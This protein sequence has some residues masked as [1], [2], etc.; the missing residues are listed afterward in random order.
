MNFIYEFPYVSLIH[1]HY[2]VMPPLGW[3]VSVRRITHTPT[4][5]HVIPLSYEHLRKYNHEFVLF[6]VHFKMQARM[7]ITWHVHQGYQTKYCA[8]ILFTNKLFLFLRCYEWH[9][10]ILMLLSWPNRPVTTNRSS[11]ERST[12]NCFKAFQPS[13]IVC[14]LR[15]T[16]IYFL[17]MRAVTPPPPRVYPCLKCQESEV[18]FQYHLC[19]CKRHGSFWIRT[20]L[21]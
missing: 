17:W 20:P 12:Y 16:F 15:Y 1:I 14:D 21:I 19:P 2:S 10:L 18:A 11:N 3:V 7:E 6:S 9:F 4:H 5:P 8:L 13:R